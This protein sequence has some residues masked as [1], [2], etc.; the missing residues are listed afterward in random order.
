ME[1][2]VAFNQIWSTKS[3]S[4]IS[5]KVLKYKGLNQMMRNYYIN[6]IK[7]SKLIKRN[8][9]NLN[10]VW[11]TKFTFAIS[12]MFNYKGLLDGMSRNYHAGMKIIMKI[13]KEKYKPW[14]KYD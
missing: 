1:T 2:M 6:I 8:N 14:I 3:P 9:I 12:I 11:S 5:F 7:K 4:I 13:S 10:K